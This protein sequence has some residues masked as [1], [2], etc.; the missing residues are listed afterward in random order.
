[1]LRASLIAMATIISAGGIMIPQAEAAPAV[2]SHG[3]P[4]PVIHRPSLHAH[5]AR[6]VQRVAEPRNRMTLSAPGAGQRLRHDAVGPVT[7]GSWLPWRYG[8]GTT[9]VILPSAP[10]RMERP[11]GLPV[12]A[13][14]RPAPVAAPVI[15]QIERGAA[16]GAE[17]MSGRH[18]HGV[19]AHR[20]GAQASRPEARSRQ[21]AAPADTTTPR[22][23]TVRVR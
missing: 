5:A 13:G 11:R 12:V 22:V 20:M 19:S 14:I 18:R 4:A 21:A 17:P 9:V 23:I 6:P 8:G 15:Y 1:M 3:H 7:I 10:V 2:R 16:A